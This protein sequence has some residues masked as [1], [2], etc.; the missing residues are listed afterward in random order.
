MK[1]Y[2]LLLLSIIAFTACSQKELQR[3]MDSVNEILSEDSG[4]LTSGEVAAGLKEALVKGTDYAVDKSGVANGFYKNPR[5]F[6][7][8]PAEAS[9]IKET[10]L[11][12]GLD[13]QVSKFEETLNRAAEQAVKEAKPIFVNAITSM[14][15]EDAFALLK[16]GDNAATDFLRQK[17]GTQL[18]SKFQ[19]KVQSAVDQVELTK[20][21]NPLASAYNTASTFTGK[22]EIN[23]DL[24]AYIT[25]RSIEG[26]FTLISDEE[27][28]IRDNPAARVTELLKKVFGA[29]D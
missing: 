26:L 14:T 13:S 4:S 28:K 2:G 23:P 5:L 12:L 6:I 25:D 24:T 27:K 11:Q 15:I 10:A 19:P 17:T 7:P 3:T 22:E 20:Y 8:F 18:F 16:G 21:Y 9:K 29:Q 1:K